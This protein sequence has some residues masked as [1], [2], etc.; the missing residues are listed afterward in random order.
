MKSPLNEIRLVDV[1]DRLAG[2]DGQLEAI[3]FGLDVHGAAFR[4]LVA[5]VTRDQLE[6]LKRDPLPPG[7]SSRGKPDLEAAE[8]TEEAA[9]LASASRSPW[10]RAT[11]EA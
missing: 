8:V 2:P 7:W 11:L 5:D 3:E 6:Q 1:C 10:S 4:L 9:R